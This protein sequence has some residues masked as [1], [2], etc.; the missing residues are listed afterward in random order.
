[1]SAERTQCQLLMLLQDAVISPAKYIRNKAHGIGDNLGNLKL[2]LLTESEWMLR[3]TS[4][5]YS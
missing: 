5:M 3:W 2:C 1:M 4:I